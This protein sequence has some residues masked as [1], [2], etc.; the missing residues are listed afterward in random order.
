[1][2]GEYLLFNLLVLA[3]P[4]ALSFWS[5]T[6]FVHL[7]PLVAAA[8]ATAAVPYVAWDA[9]VTGRHWW[10]NPEYSLPHRPPGLPPGEWLFF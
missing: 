7:W 3:G 6:R 4:V 8:A 9:W 2:P 1:M 5:R 10:F